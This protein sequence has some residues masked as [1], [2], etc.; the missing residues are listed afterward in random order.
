[1]N[2]RDPA[3]PDAG[4]QPMRNLH[5]AIEAERGARGRGTAGR[6]YAGRGRGTTR[7]APA[8]AGGGSPAAHARP[9]PP[10]EFGEKPLVCFKFAIGT[11]EKGKDCEYAHDERLAKQWLA[12]KVAL[13]SG[14]RL[15][16]RSVRATEKSHQ[17]YGLAE[18]FWMEAQNVQHEADE[19]EWEDEQ[20]GE[21]LVDGDEPLS[22]S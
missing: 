9:R 6:V 22:H 8:H 20:G 13:Y 19:G 5:G 4:P 11:C 1:M 14:A 2:W 18:Q 12:D 21:G 10:M 17:I 3:R 7:G 15:F 16:D